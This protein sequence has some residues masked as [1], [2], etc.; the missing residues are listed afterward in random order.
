M[1]TPLGHKTFESWQKAT[2]LSKLQKIE[3][4]I[5]QDMQGTAD[6]LKALLKETNSAL[7]VAE[8]EVSDI[9]TFLKSAKDDLQRYYE[10]VENNIA[11]L[12]KA[13]DEAVDLESEAERA[14][15]E[16]GLRETEL[17]GYDDMLSRASLADDAINDGDEVLKD[18]DKIL[19]NL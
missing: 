11:A 4:G 6:T 13:R 14:A 16:L 8:K 10:N 1:I 15:N 12:E 5:V 19:I 18:I 3:L 2:K 9:K 17:P 7:D